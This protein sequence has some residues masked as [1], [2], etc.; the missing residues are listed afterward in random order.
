MVKKLRDEVHRLCNQK[1]GQ[2]MNFYILPKIAVSRAFDLFSLF[3][4][5]H[6]TQQALKNLTGFGDQL[7]QPL[8]QTIY[9]LVSQSITKQHQSNSWHLD[10]Q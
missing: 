6:K 3:E 7:F 9:K 1:F 4:T 5:P 8:K 2:K 10:S